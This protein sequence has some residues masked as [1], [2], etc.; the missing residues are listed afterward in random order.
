MPVVETGYLQP[1]ERRSERRRITVRVQYRR[2]IVRLQAKV[3]DMSCHGLRLAGMERLKPG[4]TVWITFPG[5]EPR[6]ATVVWSQRFEAGCD[7]AVPLHPAVF[8]AVASRRLR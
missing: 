2:K 1:I 6:W 5:L 3:L 7:F 4:E 8:E